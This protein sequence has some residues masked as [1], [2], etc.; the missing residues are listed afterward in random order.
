[1]SMIDAEDQSGLGSHP[2]ALPVWLMQVFQAGVIAGTLGVE[3]FIL[4]LI[5][6]GQFGSQTDGPAV[7]RIANLCTIEVVLT[8][9]C[10]LL[11]WLVPGGILRRVQRPPQPMPDQATSTADPDGLMKRFS[12]LFTA[13]I[14][15]LAL[16]ELPAVFGAVVCFLARQGGQAGQHPAIWLNLIPTGIFLACGVVSFPTRQRID[17]ILH[18]QMQLACRL[19]EGHI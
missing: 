5:T 2:P 8:C 12:W 16:L 14:I 4:F 17:E 18:G 10:Y 15:R 1:M 13:R 7:L 9:S 11:A 6:P 19:A 3:A